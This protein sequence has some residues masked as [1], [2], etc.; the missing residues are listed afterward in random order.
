[1]L[2]RCDNR[3]TTETVGNPTFEQ[4]SYFLVIDLSQI[5][6]YALILP[7]MDVSGRDRL[8]VRTLRC[9]RSNPGSNPGHG[10]DFLFDDD[11]S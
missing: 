1:V 11:L 10:S 4:R 5:E 2:G 7:M 6:S 9:G 3:Y 8:V